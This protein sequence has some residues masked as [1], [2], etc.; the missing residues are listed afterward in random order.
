MRNFKGLKRLVVKIGTNLLTRE[1]SLDIEYMYG[2]CRQIVDIKAQGMQV[3]LVSSG[4]IGMGAAELGIY[5]KVTDIKTRQACAAIGQPLLMRQYS[6]IFGKYRTP[7]AQVLL[8]REVF[9]NRKT[10]LNLK[11]SVETLLSL[12]V[13]PIIN[14]NDSIS[15]AE[16]GT[17]FG[18][19]D[20]LSAYVASKIDAGLLIILT[21]IEGLYEQDPRGYPKARL[22]KVVSE[23]TPEILQGAGG[24]GSTFSTGGMKTKLNAAVIAGAAGCRTIIAHGKRDGILIRLLK[25]EDEGTLFLAGKRLSARARWI[26]NS[27]PRGTLFV[28][29]GALDAL[30]RSKSLLPSGIIS[31]EG[32]FNAGDVVLINDCAHTVSSFTST[33][34]EN[35]IGRHSDEIEKIVGVGRRDVIARPEDIVFL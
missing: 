20:S 19:N 14:E 8:T 4:A 35:L 12:G 15:T 1:N 6:E 16:I 24:G 30:H 26:L 23:I 3:L 27:V 13:I 33:E 34:I 5:S 31:V 29:S 18:D 22:I 2:I 28:D 32:L 9:N 7:I 10:F 25:G 11:N 21:D 17:A